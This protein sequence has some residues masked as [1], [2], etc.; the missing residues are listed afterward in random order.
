[1]KKIIL[2][3]F[4]LV[5]MIT[6]PAQAV[7]FW[8]SDTTWAN[9]G[10]CSAEF[11]F[12]SGGPMANDG[13]ITDMNV[14]VSAY[15]SKNHKVDSGVLHID[16]FGASEADR[17]ASAFLES[18]AMCDK[19]LTIVV[20]RAQ[21]RIAGKPVDLLKTHQLRGRNFVPFTIKVTQARP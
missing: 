18:A 17:Y 6:G 15:D 21:A 13:P 8:H 3:A 7:E 20:D 2:S 14:S 16:E 1:M 10:I 11:T 9:G 19:H 5:M 12:D 4:S